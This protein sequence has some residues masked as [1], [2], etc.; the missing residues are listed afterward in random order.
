LDYMTWVFRCQVRRNSY[1][2]GVRNSILSLWYNFSELDRL[3]IDAQRSN[4]WHLILLT[5]S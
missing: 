3:R 4:D 2:D 5:G 1:L